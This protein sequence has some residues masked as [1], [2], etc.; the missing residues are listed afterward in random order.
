M[1]KINSIT[2][3]SKVQMTQEFIISKIN[4]KSVVI[5]DSKGNVTIVRDRDFGK[6]TTAGTKTETS[7]HT[8]S[9]TGSLKGRMPKWANSTPKINFVKAE[10]KEGRSATSASYKEFRGFQKQLRDNS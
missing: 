9:L 6:Y 7:A 8:T 10:R 4:K 2:K 1:I 3:G 5:S